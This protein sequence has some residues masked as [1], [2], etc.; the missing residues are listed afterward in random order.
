M[1]N[2]FA[3]GKEVSGRFFTDREEETVELLR[4]LKRGQNVIIYS[5]RRYGKTSLIKKVL[6]SLRKDGMITI[7]IDLYKATS[8]QKLIDVFA[9]S[10]AEQTESNL[11]KGFAVIKELLP[12]LLPKIIFRQTGLP[13]IEFEYNRNQSIMPLLSDV[14][15][16][17][18]K[19]SK[20]RK[21]NAVVVFDEFQE[22]MNFEDDEIE[23]EMRSHFQSHQN[24]SY[25]FLGSKQ[26]LMKKLFLDKSRPFYNSGK[27]FPLGKIENEKFSIFIKNN[28]KSNGMKID[29][30]TIGEILG[31]TQGHPY[32]TQ[33]LCNVLWDYCVENKIKF[34]KNK[35]V[36]LALDKVLK[37]ESHAYIEIWE[38]I[39]GNARLVLEAMAKQDFVKAFS[40]AFL[41]ENRLGTASSIQRAIKILENRGLIEKQEGSYYIADVFFKLWIIQNILR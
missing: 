5:P 29:N 2:P 35:E 6:E 16:L 17:V 21:K 11:K 27:H 34:I 22:I 23:R 15:E 14:L 41:L 40:S 32:Y 9:K 24:I 36:D 30:E 13:E 8:K 26:H 1:D 33:L 25:V 39:R 38:G 18:H 7:Y 28:F 19:I 31:K 37:R 10:V 3:Y 4:D 20:K 12:K